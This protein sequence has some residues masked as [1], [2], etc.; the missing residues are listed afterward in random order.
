MHSRRVAALIGNELGRTLG[1][2]PQNGATCDGQ[3]RRLEVPGRSETR[4]DGRL[5]IQNQVVGAGEVA[6]GSRSTTR[7]SPAPP[8]VAE[9]RNPTSSQLFGPNSPPMS[10]A[11]GA[12]GSERLRA[13]AARPRGC[14]SAEPFVNSNAVP[15]KGGATAA[16]HATRS[17]SGLSG[18]IVLRRCAI[19]PQGV[20]RRDTSTGRVG[21]QWRSPTE[22]RGER[23]AVRSPLHRHVCHLGHLLEKSH[24]RAPQRA[25]IANAPVTNGSFET[26]T[27]GSSGAGSPERVAASSRVG[28]SG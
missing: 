26:A 10:Y 18:G 7:G 21:G 25:C 11:A 8:T 4:G 6:M 12:A 3:E 5:L 28:A 2:V 27:S 17:S 13:A 23:R 14:P 19:R 15:R 1:A 24:A 16:L 20:S 9:E 22:R